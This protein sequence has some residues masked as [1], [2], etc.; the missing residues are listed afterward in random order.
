MN[1]NT[2][3]QISMETDHAS[4]RLK[5]VWRGPFSIA[6]IADSCR[7]REREGAHA[8]AQLID[9]TEAEVG[10]S[11]EDARKIPTATMKMADHSKTLGPAGRT[12]V[13]VASTL[14]FGV[15]RR[16]ATYFEEAGEIG[17]FYNEADAR[18]WLNWRP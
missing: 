17:V 3:P 8:Y 14:D 7:Q 16:I 15:C 18:R 11:V 5:T 6:V 9:A 12:A 2:E 4:R 1:T 13:V 10:H